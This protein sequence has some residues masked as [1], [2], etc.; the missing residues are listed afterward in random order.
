M[1]VSL[2]STA[3]VYCKAADLSVTIHEFITIM[4]LK[5]QFSPIKPDISSGTPRGP[6]DEQNSCN[7]G[8]LVHQVLGVW[9]G[10]QRN[11]CAIDL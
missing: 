7:M 2:Q 4:L 3:V 5:V 9:M 6:S 10:K 11:P 8:L 1:S